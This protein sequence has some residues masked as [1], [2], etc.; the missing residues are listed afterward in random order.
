[1]FEKLFSGHHFAHEHHEPPIAP[2]PAVQ[3]TLP[4]NLKLPPEEFDQEWIYERDASIACKEELPW[5]D[6]VEKTRNQKAQQVLAHLQQMAKKLRERGRPVTGPEYMN[7][8]MD[9][10]LEMAKVRWNH[11][12]GRLKR[13]FGDKWKF[14]MS[15]PI[16]AL[17]GVRA[18]DAV[19][20]EAVTVRKEVRM[21]ALVEK[22]DEEKAKEGLEPWDGLDRGPV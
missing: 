5:L 15:R 12:N 3:H 1:M 6:F 18:A 2:L 10:A 21:N 8:D 16:W 9:V 20:V 4:A 14:G 19:D 17:E 22:Q 7:K 13:L 11:E